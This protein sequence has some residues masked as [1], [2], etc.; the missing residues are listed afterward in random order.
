MDYRIG[1]AGKAGRSKELPQELIKAAQK[2]GHEVAKNQG[3]LINGSCMG[4]SHA[5]SE[6]AC[7]SE[8]A[9][10]GCSPAKNLQEHVQPPVSYPL[11]PVGMHLVFTGTGKVDRNVGWIRESE[12]VVFVG[13]GIGTLNELTLAMHEG[14]VIGVLDGVEGVLNKISLGSLV[15]DKFSG[16]IVRDKDP[17]KLVKKVIDEIRK[18]RNDSYK[19][20]IPLT[21]KNGNGKQ[22]MGVFC[23]PGKHKTPLVIATHGMGKNCSEDKFVDLGR[24]LSENNIAF[25][26]FDFEGCGNSEGELKDLTVKNEVNDLNC[27]I[28]EVRKFGDV[29]P[30]QFALVGD[31]L[32]AVVNCLLAVETG[33]S[34]NTLVLWS[35]A[36]NQG[37]LLQKWNTKEEIKQW[38]K[39]K[40]LI[41]GKRRLG[42][43]YLKENIKADYSYL[44]GK[45]SQKKI[46]VLIIHGDADKDVP[47][48]YSQ[49]LADRYANVSLKI[50]KGADHKMEDYFSRQKLI[51]HTRAHLL[52]N[53]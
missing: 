24:K 6:A 39:E 48:K 42:I 7:K 33:V 45:L 11:P 3:I 32:G 34:I 19:K 29:E 23:F 51:A 53:L 13:G 30:S 21:F 25:F 40:V 28:K 20:E 17:Q 50:I 1:I 15:S 22:L 37:E 44:L 52:K 18:A 49:K 46:S 10:L 26:R 4:V 27:A 14:K 41:K 35:P 16:V 2:I 12:G 43:E 36:F 38:Q 5:A 8:G 47:V 31:S 9:V